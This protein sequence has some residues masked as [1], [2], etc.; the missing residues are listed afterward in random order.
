MLDEIDK[1]LISELEKDGRAS[2]AELAHKLGIG[3]STVARR[4]DRLVEDNV[5]KF[6]TIRNITKLGLNAAVIV[7]LDVE[8]NRVHDVAEKLVNV[9]EIHYVSVLMG[10]FD[11]IF[12]GYFESQESV[13]EFL[14]NRV[15]K[16]EGVTNIETFFIAE[17]KKR[18]GG[19][20]PKD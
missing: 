14:N 16:M 2:Y 5:I 13:F 11:I 3:L 19:L 20:F 18:Y 15:S 8:F 17:N 9:P 4:V 12:F 6:T 1:K 7:A 10:R